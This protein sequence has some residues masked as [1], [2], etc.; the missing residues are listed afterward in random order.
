MPR[1]NRSGPNRPGGVLPSPLMTGGVSLGAVHPRT[2]PST[3]G[4]NGGG[5]RHQTVG[6]VEVTPDGTVTKRSERWTVTP[7]KLSDDA[8]RRRWR[9]WSSPGH[10]PPAVPRG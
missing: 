7:G 4:G 9:P 1:R 3:N 5:H 8:G 6:T 2:A 10:R